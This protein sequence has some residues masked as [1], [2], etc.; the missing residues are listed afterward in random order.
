MLVK[1]AKQRIVYTLISKFKQNIIVIIWWRIC[2][3]IRLFSYM[4]DMF[5]YLYLYCSSSPCKA[6]FI[7]NMF[8]SN[9]VI[10]QNPD[11]TCI[12]LVMSYEKYVC[13]KHFE[14]IF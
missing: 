7:G 3:N 2:T 11:Q 1:Q 6:N 8:N 4:K 14:I 10:Y 12:W 5:N 9:S 13:G